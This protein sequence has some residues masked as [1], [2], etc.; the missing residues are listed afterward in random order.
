MKTTLQDL[1]NQR[2]FLI[3]RG[4]PSRTVHGNKSCAGTTSEAGIQA[5][6]RTGIAVALDYII[7]APDL[8]FQSLWISKR[9]GV[10]PFPRGSA[11]ST[12]RRASKEQETGTAFK[13]DRSESTGHMR[14]CDNDVHLR[15]P[16][17]PAVPDVPAYAAPWVEGKLPPE[18]TTEHNMG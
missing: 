15:R 3:T 5:N 6:L 12:P 4:L 13:P 1:L 10:G 2:E 16:L 9:L 7:R 17:T 18:F 14:A 11:G 8:G